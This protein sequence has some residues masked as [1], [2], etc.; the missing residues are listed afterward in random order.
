MTVTRPRHPR[1]KKADVVKHPEVFN[2]V[3]LL[4]NGPVAPATCPSSSHPTSLIYISLGVQLDTD[5][6][7]ILP[8]G[9]GK[10][11]RCPVTSLKSFAW[12]TI[13]FVGIASSCLL[14][15]DGRRTGP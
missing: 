1:D 11:S 9:T 13:G 14:L 3:G 2:H 10:A 12:M 6:I 15:C 8:R 4:F 5:G 7:Y